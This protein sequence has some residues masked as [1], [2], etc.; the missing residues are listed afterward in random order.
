MPLPLA[1]FNLYPCTLTDTT[2]SVTAFSEFCESYYQII[3]E[4]DGLGG[5]V[6]YSPRSSL[7]N[8]KTHPDVGSGVKTSVFEAGC[9]ERVLTMV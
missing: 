6:A 7:C 5:P 9:P 1:D 8:L 4:E 3:R 2:V